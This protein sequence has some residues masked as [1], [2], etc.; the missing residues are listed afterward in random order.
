MQEIEIVK[1]IIRVDDSKEKEKADVIMFDGD[2]DEYQV[3]FRDKMTGEYLS[4]DVLCTD[5]RARDQFK[6]GN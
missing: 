5:V 2:G 6:K 3:K 1:T 4:F